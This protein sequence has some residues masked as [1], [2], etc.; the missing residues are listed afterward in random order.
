[1]KN[2]SILNDVMGPVM[3]GPS[4]S[5]TA[6]AYRIALLACDLL[7]EPAAR[8]G[9]TFDPNGSYAPTYRPLGVDLAFAAGCLG[10]EMADPRYAEALDAVAAS[11][12]DLSFRVGDLERPNHPNAV[13]VE[14]T[15]A[16]GGTLVLH[17]RAIGGG[18][19]DVD[20]LG[21]F[22]IA[23][24]GRRHATFVECVG[25]D[26]P[27][28]R[29]QVERAL[30][31]S[32]APTRRTH[33]DQVQLQWTSD[34][35]LPDHAL[36]ALRAGPGV[37]A[38]RRARP[39]LLPQLGEADYDSASLLIQH[40]TVAGESLATMARRSEA[41][42]LGRP[43]SE[44]DELIWKRY[45]I[46]RSSVEQG[47]RD[48]QVNL[49]LTAPSAARIADSDQRGVLPLGGI[50][51][52]V[53]ARALAAMHVCNSKG[54]ICAAPTGGSAGTIP[55]VLVTMEQEQG[56]TREQLTRAM[57][58]A[59][60]IGAV[61]ARRATFAAEIAGCQV[62]IGV[63][64]AMAAAAVVEV[65]GG[66]PGQ[67]GDAAAVSLQNTMGTVC[68]SVGGGC[69]IPCQSRN[70]VAAANA[71]LCADMVVGGFPNPIPLD[72]TIDAS[73]EVGKQLPS[74]LRCTAGGG[75]AV[76]PSAQELVRCCGG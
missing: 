45:E 70:A 67:A 32:Q 28:L 24:D 13:L 21:P 76:T 23:L 48:D 47:M 8:I 10:W 58:T 50:L 62:E 12:I 18:I 65:A 7:G 57:W 38:V 71:F 68:D 54:V 36:D 72:E 27:S 29:Q 22:Q 53:G 31:S 17:A 61:V 66:S 44:L 59:G 5:H 55:G 63:A 75:L 43:E 2:V 39:V 35:P 3:R 74:S 56:R 33:G 4:S 6:G 51:T 14:M 64:G 16:S 34:C 9:L 40:A 1:M 25:A 26:E 19:V 46:M 42:L 15:G 49:P 30:G 20:G 60:F 52:R 37:S 73:Y 69:E 11:G 41:R